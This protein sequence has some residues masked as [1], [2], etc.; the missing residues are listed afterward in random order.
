MAR[1][2]GHNVL[3]VATDAELTA[4]DAFRRWTK[5]ARNAQTSVRIYSPY[6]DELALTVLRASSLEQA[7]K[8]VVTD[9]SPQSG[10]QD[11]MAQLKALRRLVAEGVAVRSLPRLHAKVLMTD[12]RH[13]TVGSQNF[14]RYARESKE[15]THL[16]AADLSGTAF[17]DQL[18]AWYIEATPVSLDFL[19]R[20]INAVKQA[21]RRVAAAQL[22]LT[23]AY[24]AESELQE[25]QVAEEQM[26]RNRQKARL[27]PV[28]YGLEEARQ[29]TRYRNATACVF[30]RLRQREST[31]R[32][33]WTLEVSG[34]GDLNRW[35]RVD[36]TGRERELQLFRGAMY[37]MLI[38]P[39]GRLAFVTLPATTITF[40]WRSLS[41]LHEYT[42]A[43][44]RLRLS[45][46]F[47]D[48]APDGRNLL[49]QLSQVDGPQSATLTF[50]FDGLTASLTEA[51]LT[52][53]R[54]PWGSTTV[55]DGM[56]ALVAHQGARDQVLAE[57]LDEIRHPRNF[58]NAEYSM[59]RLFAHTWYEITLVEF[60]GR[61]VLLASEC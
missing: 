53:D 3:V 20:L 17:L 11:Y 4:G 14:T 15:T 49:V 36:D 39:Q 28:E 34:D 9:L 32:Y 52:G 13:V 58:K 16:P 29:S 22:E 21:A 26:R 12:G 19:D 51:E 8:S 37:P 48:E 42:I 30:A 5:R 1:T 60:L 55:E 7:A 47:P 38:N 6:L 59:D 43:G 56:A 45:V 2:I 23:E 46:D 24:E 27:V 33:Y 10:A 44:N 40:A 31:A 61:H 41:W 35:V 57:V 50:R 54:D 18:N 25:R